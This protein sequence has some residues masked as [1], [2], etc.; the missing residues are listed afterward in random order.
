[1]KIKIPVQYWF[2]GSKILGQMTLEMESPDLAV[3]ARLQALWELRQMF[4]QVA[5]SN[6][7]KSPDSKAT[8]DIPE[9]YLLLF[10]AGYHNTQSGYDGVVTK[11][12]CRQIEA[13]LFQSGKYKLPV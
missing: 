8:K 2:I 11:E 9:S 6:E 13:G 10:Y 1:M 12:I 7:R 5:R 3:Q 4:L